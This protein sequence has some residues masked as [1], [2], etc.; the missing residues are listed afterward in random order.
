MFGADRETEPGP[1]YTGLNREF[2]LTTF[3]IKLAGPTST[4]SERA[5]ALN[6]AKERGV[7]VQLQNDAGYSRG[8]KCFN[9]SWCSRYPHEAERL[10]MASRKPLRL[11]SVVLIETSLNFQS[12][13]SALFKFD[14]M[15]S[16]GDIDPL[17]VTKKDLRIIQ[18]LCLNQLEPS[19]V[20]SAKIP[21]YISRCFS[22]WSQKR[23]EIQ[24]IFII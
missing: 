10:F 2:L 1:F 8:A 22:L 18:K 7:V 19:A 9:V 3:Y 24:M 4:S 21:E 12:Y 15:L 6:F 11:A 20:D 16:L 17:Y 13:F 23:E 14:A 5:T